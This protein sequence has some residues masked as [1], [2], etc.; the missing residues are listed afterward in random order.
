ML[1]GTIKEQSAAKQSAKAL[2]HSQKL[3]IIIYNAKE[4]FITDWY[5]NVLE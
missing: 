3:F 1:Y 4:L 2:I 5:C